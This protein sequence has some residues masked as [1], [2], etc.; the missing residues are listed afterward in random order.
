MQLK[1]L[2]FH[3]TSESTRMGFLSLF[4]SHQHLVI[5]QVFVCLFTAQLFEIYQE[6]CM[7]IS[8]VLPLDTQSLV[9]SAFIHILLLALNFFPM[10]ALLG[11]FSLSTLI[12]LYSPNWF[13]LTLSWVSPS[14]PRLIFLVTST[15]SLLYIYKCLSLAFKALQIKAQTSLVHPITHHSFHI[16]NTLNFCCSAP[17][18]LATC[19]H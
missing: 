13:P 12:Q 3:E 11:L 15:V 17:Q 1:F 10:A 2:F 14:Q 16:T 8:S 18:P 7:N 6:P 9:D 4:G 19:G 5:T